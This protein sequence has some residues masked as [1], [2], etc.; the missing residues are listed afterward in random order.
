MFLSGLEVSVCCP[1]SDIC[2]RAAG[3][4]LIVCWTWGFADNRLG[5]FPKVGNSLPFALLQ[6]FSAMPGE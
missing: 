5:Q 6:S 2:R 4:A 1:V 3:Q